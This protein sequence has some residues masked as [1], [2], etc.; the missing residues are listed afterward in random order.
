MA[1]STGISSRVID[2]HVGDGQT[3]GTVDADGLHRG[4][5]DMEVGD[6]GV[7]KRMSV[8][9][10]GL[11]NTTVASLSI[12]PRGSVAVEVGASGS[13]DLNTGTLD[14]EKRSRPFGVRP[15]CLALEDDL[16]NIYQYC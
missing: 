7:D 13:A 14:L 2:G 6:G 10:F 8:E 5:L 16:C 15:G 11:G 1:E 12:P 3:I 9:E 4:I